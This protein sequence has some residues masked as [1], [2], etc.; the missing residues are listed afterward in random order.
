MTEFNKSSGNPSVLFF[1]LKYKISGN[2]TLH[3]QQLWLDKVCGVKLPPAILQA[4]SKPA[5]TQS[6]GLVGTDLSVKPA[7]LPLAH[8]KAKF[9][10]LLRSQ[11]ALTVSASRCWVNP[12][13]EITLKAHL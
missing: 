7:V 12:G 13:P 3:I 9:N 8:S 1:F 11:K 4:S 5:S 2:R 6:L 10:H